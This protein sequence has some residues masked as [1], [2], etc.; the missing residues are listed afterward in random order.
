MFPDKSGIQ[1][2]TIVCMLDS[3][4]GQKKE[5]FSIAIWVYQVNSKKSQPWHFLF[6]FVLFK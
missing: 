6:I 5:D 3:L 4:D 2:L 1:N